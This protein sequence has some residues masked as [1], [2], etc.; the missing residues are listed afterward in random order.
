MNSFNRRRRRFFENPHDVKARRLA[1]FT[2]FVALVV[3]E[4]RR[5]SYHRA[6]FSVFVQLDALDKL[7]PDFAQNFRCNVGGRVNFAAAVPGFVQLKVADKSFRGTNHI[8]RLNDALILRH[9]PDGNFAVVVRENHARQ[10]SFARRKFQQAFLAADEVASQ[11]IGRAEVNA[12]NVIVIHISNSSTSAISAAP[13]A[14]RRS[15]IL[16]R[17]FPSRRIFSFSSGGSDFSYSAGFS[18][19]SPRYAASLKFEKV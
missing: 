3:V 17:I 5:Y 6:N 2:G 1:S 9:L 13:S 4:V 15:K 7:P 14:T 11:R 16:S 10:H 8:V 19:T 12:Q 18:F